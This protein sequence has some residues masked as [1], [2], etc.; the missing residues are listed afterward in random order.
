M[1]LF[2]CLFSAVN[3]DGF[4]RRHHSEAYLFQN[5]IC[6]TLSGAYLLVDVVFILFLRDVTVGYCNSVLI[7]WT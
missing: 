2:V 1:N 7:R 3:R 5:I 6:F 4:K